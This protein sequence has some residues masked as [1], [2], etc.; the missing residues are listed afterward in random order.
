[1]IVDRS[2][3]AAAGG[4][5]QLFDRRPFGARRCG[6]REPTVLIVDRSVPAAAGGENQLF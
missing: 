1:L 3:L 4:E 5:N 2:V 6:R